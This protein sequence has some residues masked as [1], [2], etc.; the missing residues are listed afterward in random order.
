MYYLRVVISSAD[1]CAQSIN[2]QLA[3]FNVNNNINIIIRS[4]VVYY[5]LRNNLQDI[6]STH[7][8]PIFIFIWYRIT[9]LLNNIA[10]DWMY[11]IIYHINFNDD[12]NDRHR[13]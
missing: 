1:A 13:P 5:K 9:T 2:A 8:F 7:F 6:Y 10:L 3:K 4:Y 11:I 12:D